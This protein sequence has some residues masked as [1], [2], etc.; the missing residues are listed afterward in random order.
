MLKKATA[1]RMLP[2]TG[3]GLSWRSIQMVMGFSEDE[4]D[5]DERVGVCIAQ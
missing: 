2:M 4:D 3:S 1:P 5:D